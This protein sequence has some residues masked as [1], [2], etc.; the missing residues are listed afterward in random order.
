MPFPEKYVE[1]NMYCLN[2]RW[3]EQERSCER[4]RCLFRRCIRR[5]GLRNGSTRARPSM[6]Q[7]HSQQWLPA[8]T[9][10]L[11]S[12]VCAT[13]DAGAASADKSDEFAT[14]GTIRAPDGLTGK[15]PSKVSGV[16]ATQGDRKVFVTDAGVVLKTE[17]VTD[18]IGTNAKSVRVAVT[19]KSIGGESTI[20]KTETE[21]PKKIATVVNSAPTEEGRALLTKAVDDLK[22]KATETLSSSSEQVLKSYADVITQGRDAVVKVFMQLPQGQ[23]DQQAT[24]A[25][26]GKVYL[27]ARREERSKQKAFY[28]YDDQWSPKTYST[29]FEWCNPIAQLSVKDQPVGTCFLVG[30]NLV[31]TCEHC[32]V[33][34]K[35]MGDCKLADLS[36]TFFKEG[37]PVETLKYPVV[38][39]PER[40]YAEA[41]IPGPPDAQKLDFAFLELG[42]S[43]AKQTPE[44]DGL[45]PVALEED[46]MLPRDTAVY[47]VGYPLGGGKMVADNAHIFVPYE[48]TNAAFH[49][50]WLELN[51]ELEERKDEVAKLKDGPYKRNEQLQYDLLA[52]EL[53]DSFRKSFKPVPNSSDLLFDSAFMYPQTP[54]IAIDTDTF[55][56][57]SGSP[58]FLRKTSKVVALF[59]RGWGDEDRA[60]KATWKQHEEAVPIS[61]ILQHWR[62]TDR[63]G[64][65]KYGIESPSLA[66]AAATTITAAGQ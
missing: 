50:Y 38:G 31:L 23:K 54:A 48:V 20:E 62:Q 29:I 37:S 10:V 60:K 8:L 46:T 13:T 56:G 65:A 2:K 28:G 21:L 58:V 36:V 25:E 53:R 57:N 66:A 7:R 17:N 39:I 22:Q 11:L 35:M 5:V 1:L 44:Q 43:S 45:K 34:K 3:E 51:G 6:Q 41:Y 24:A 64:P 12:Y 63:N 55:H 33:D 49:A 9:C 61:A 14:S 30:K 26:W 15:L 16:F 27:E 40:G 42:Q 4:W 59:L 47:V 18:D 52:Q 19:L 32:V